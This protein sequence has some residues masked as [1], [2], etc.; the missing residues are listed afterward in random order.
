MG[1]GHFTAY[2]SSQVTAC[3]SSQ[4]TAYGSSQVTACDSSQVRA[5]GSS[6]VRAYDSSQ[7]TACGSSQVRAYDSSQVTAYDSSQVTACGSSQVTAYDSSQV[8]AYDSSQVTACDYVAVTRT[9]PHIKVSGGVVIDVPDLN[10]AVEWCRYY[11]IDVKRGVATVFKAVDDDY[12]SGY[13]ADYTPGKK[14]KADD[15]D[16]TPTCGGGLH[17]SPR[18]F[19]A[20]D[21]AGGATRFLACR[22]KVSEMVALGDKIK[23]PRVLSCVEVNEDGNA[24]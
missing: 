22:V 20:L 2:G 15:W 9:N 12:K 10:D 13:G 3:D 11:G 24:I 8:R 23:A 14:P 17:F 7:V 4:V 18:P 5:C 19:M 16:P 1:A 6:Q 21:Y